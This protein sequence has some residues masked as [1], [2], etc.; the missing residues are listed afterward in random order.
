[1]GLLTDIFN[2]FLSTFY[3]V[4][5]GIELFVKVIKILRYVFILTLSHRLGVPSNGDGCV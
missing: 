2:F 4:V 5:K 3:N 1:M